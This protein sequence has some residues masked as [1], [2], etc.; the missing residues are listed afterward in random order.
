MDFVTTFFVKGD[1]SFKNYLLKIYEKINLRLDKKEYFNNY[2][3]NYFNEN[4]FDKIL[5]I[6]ISN[7]IEI[8]DKFGG[9]SSE[10]IRSKRVT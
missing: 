6:I 10:S 4:F 8:Q 9:N 1:N 2:L 3:S 5:K 7:S